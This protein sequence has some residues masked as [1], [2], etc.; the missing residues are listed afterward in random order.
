[1]AVALLVSYA[2]ATALTWVLEPA[3]VMLVMGLVLA[4]GAAT[5]SVVPTLRRV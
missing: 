4:A 1:M 5:A 2:L 3:I